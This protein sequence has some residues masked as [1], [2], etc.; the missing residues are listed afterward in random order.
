[1]RSMQDYAPVMRSHLAAHAPCS[2]IPGGG[3][4]ECERAGTCEQLRER[5]A[6]VVRAARVEAVSR[7]MVSTDEVRTRDAAQAGGERRGEQERTDHRCLE[8]GRSR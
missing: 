1:M 3:F 7:V 2:A 6:A 5:R 8:Q 4:G